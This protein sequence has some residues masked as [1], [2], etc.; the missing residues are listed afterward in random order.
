MIVGFGSGGKGSLIH[1]MFILFHTIQVKVYRFNLQTAL[2]NMNSQLIKIKQINW[3]IEYV[4]W[5]KENLL[6]S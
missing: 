5:P 4:W 1:W 6:S 2:N 3:Y